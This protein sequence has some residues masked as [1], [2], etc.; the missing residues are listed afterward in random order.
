[1]RQA[2][3]SRMCLA[4]V[5]AGTWPPASLASRDR[6]RLARPGRPAKD[7]AA[8]QF[9]QGP[10]RLAQVS[11]VRRRH[12]Q[13]PAR[14]GVRHRR[15]LITGSVPAP[16]FEAALVEATCL[17]LAM[18]TSVHA[19]AAAPPDG[20]LA[21]GART[22]DDESPQS[23]DARG[24]QAR[25]AAGTAR[26]AKDAATTV[27]RVKV[28][29]YGAKPPVWRRLEIPSAMPL[30]LVHAVLQVAF[31]WHDYHLHVFETVCG[32]FGSPD[33]AYAWAE[34]QDETTAVLIPGPSN[35]QAA[36]DTRRDAGKVG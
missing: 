31:D 24:R 7:Q 27:H 6:R 9:E 35:D 26:T 15:V 4:V 30:N 12:G 33:Q 25:Q 19:A 36:A 1:V 2:E 8:Q 13:G 22:T 29:L 34:Q 5:C 28:N 11:L 17:G 21:R 23:G 10:D 18:I 20:E 14:S 3:L 16:D 32:Q